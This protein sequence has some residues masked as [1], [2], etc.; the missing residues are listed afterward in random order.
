MSYEGERLLPDDS[1][2][3]DYAGL[4][5]LVCTNNFRADIF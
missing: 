2:K 5:F 4:V 3:K 1:G